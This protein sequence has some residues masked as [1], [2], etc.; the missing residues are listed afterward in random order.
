LE[1]FV[2]DIMMLP[3]EIEG[4]AGNDPRIKPKVIN[5]AFSNTPGYDPGIARSLRHTYKD[6][7]LEWNN[8]GRNAFY[9]RFAYSP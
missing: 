9:C 2:K 7:G 6:Q 1:L 5:P 3:M 8:S 4:L